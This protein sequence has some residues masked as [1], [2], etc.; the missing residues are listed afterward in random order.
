[1]HL[2]EGVFCPHYQKEERKGFDVLDT[3]SIRKIGCV[4]KAAFVKEEDKEFFLE[5]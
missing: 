1:M 4:D 2:I 3:G 5:G